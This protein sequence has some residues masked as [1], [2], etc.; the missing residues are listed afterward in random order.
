MIAV[1]ERTTAFALY[2]F[3]LVL[4]LA[5]LPVAVLA[6]QGGLTLPVGRLVEWSGRVYAS[7]RDVR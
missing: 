7:S 1:I 3:S 2:Q 6:R 5:L 4:G